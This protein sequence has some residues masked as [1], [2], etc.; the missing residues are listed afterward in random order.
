MAWT[1]PTTRSTGDLITAAIWNQDIVDN[2]N[3]E[4]PLGVGAWTAWTPTLGN[5]T[6]GN[7]TVTA[8]YQRIGRVIY[9]SFKFVLGSTSAVG[10]APTF[11]LPAAPAVAP[12]GVFFPFG[13]ANLYDNA[14]NN[15]PGVVVLSSGG[16]VEIKAINAAGTYILTANV[17]ATAPFTWTNTD[18]V[19]AIGVYQAAS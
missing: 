19:H 14:T 1:A 10:T 6:L 3:A 7:G 13:Q 12:Y 5:L 8:Q 9:W 11:T 16:I 17:T 4:F 2:T 18:E 15:Y